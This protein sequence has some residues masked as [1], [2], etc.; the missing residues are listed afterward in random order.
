MRSNDE[1][2][3]TTRHP[4]GAMPDGTPVE[5]FTLVN[6]N[7]IEIRTIPFGCVIVSLLTPDRYGN[8]DDIV[9][10]YDTLA[11]YLGQSSYF[12]AVVGRYANRIAGG[13][14]VLDGSR[15][16]LTRNDGRNHL[17]GGDRGFD[18]HLW[19]ADE[20]RT[21][22]GRGIVYSRISEDGEQGYPGTLR[23]RVRYVLTDGDD[24]EIDYE[25][26]TSAP[27]IVNMTQHSYFN[28]ACGVSGDVLGQQLTLHADRFTPVNADLIPTGAL[29]S[30][31]DTAFDFTRPTAIGA[32]ID[33]AD[34]QLKH[35]GGYDHNWVLRGGARG[36]LARAARLV[37][38]VS[39]RVLEVST[40]EPGIQFYSGNQLDG[41]TGKR[42]RRH[43][44]RAG[45]CLETQHFPDGPN[46][47][48]F[49]S[50]VL[51]PGTTYRSRTVLHFG[52][53]GEWTTGEY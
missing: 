43:G 9:L 32:R 26:A 1:R 4:F 23:A 20:V 50:S 46:Q 41:V 42:G 6:A 36:E 2:E 35:G 45:L 52:T 25:A 37:D 31:D 19:G 24:L 47:P 13:E 30:V 8:R 51:R 15:Y 49:P 14:F 22:N 7:G 38:P 21:S 12:G 3:V 17:H 5:A 18:K 28:L 40:T 39:G 10:G 29:A 48:R 44:R 33:A 11:E 53:T 16:Q 27:T 34:P